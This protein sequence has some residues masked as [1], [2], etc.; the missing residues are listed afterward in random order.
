ML[1]LERGDLGKLPLSMRKSNLQRLL[2]RR[3][4]GMQLAPVARSAISSSKV[5]GAPAARPL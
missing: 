1:A 5:T 4:D 3:V 2:A